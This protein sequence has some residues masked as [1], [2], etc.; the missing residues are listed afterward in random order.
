[1]LLIRAWEAGRA[2][3]SWDP[4]D[5]E[6]AGLL[7]RVLVADRTDWDSPAELNDLFTRAAATLNLGLETAVAEAPEGDPLRAALRLLREVRLESLF[8]LGFTRTLEVRDAALAAAPEGDDAWTT[9][10][11]PP[12]P[13]TIRG[14]RFKR[15][16]LWTG[17]IGEKEPAYREFRTLAEAASARAGM[18]L[19][20]ALRALFESVSAK[21]VAGALAGWRKG[22]APIRL[23]ALVNTLLAWEILEGRAELRPLPFAKFSSLRRAILGGGGDV[24]PRYDEIFAA[25]LGGLDGKVRD[26]AGAFLDGC[27]DRLRRE[28]ESLDTELPDP[29]SLGSLLVAPR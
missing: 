27:L 16:L 6:M 14:A 12:L 24:R 26:D 20:G 19:A 4:L 7:N 3:G 15:P 9:L 5:E 17:W 8:R 28:L 23:P 22:R 29:R 1:M 2:E 13:E 18:Q 21:A 11:D 25:W 10:L